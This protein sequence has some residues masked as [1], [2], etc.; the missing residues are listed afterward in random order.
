MDYNGNLIPN[1]DYIPNII[2][3][4]LYSGDFELS[5]SILL[6][7]INILV[8][9]KLKDDNNSKKY[10]FLKFYENPEACHNKK[11]LILVFKNNNHYEIINYKD[12]SKI[13][14]LNF[15]NDTTK[16]NNNNNSILSKRKYILNYESNKNL[17]I[18]KKK[19][20]ICQ[21]F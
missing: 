7:N 12:N 8:I 18:I 20:L 21:I 13:K 16:I 3:N 2:K 5:E 6:F 15:I 10:K 11:L 9:Q 17:E 1:N 14:N 19:K 4:S